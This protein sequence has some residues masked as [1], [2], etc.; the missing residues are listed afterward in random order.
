MILG[1]S[2]SDKGLYESLRF[3]WIS[4][5]SELVLEFEGS[6][7]STVISW[8]FATPHVTNIGGLSN[9]DI[10][11]SVLDNVT[12]VDDFISTFDKHRALQSHCFQHVV[13]VLSLWCDLLKMGEYLARFPCSFLLVELAVI[14]RFV[15]WNFLIVPTLT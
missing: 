13:I 1:K 6:W 7:I 11:I 15:I 8:G 10:S 2:Y 9:Y 3:S 4:I 12:F 5:C 14:R